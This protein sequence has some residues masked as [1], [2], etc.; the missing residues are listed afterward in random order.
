[1]PYAFQKY[2]QS[3][4]VTLIWGDC[5]PP[6]TDDLGE[7]LDSRFYQPAYYKTHG[8]LYA[9][10]DA[11]P[12][13]RI[14]WNLAS[15]QLAAQPFSGPELLELEKL[16]Q[17]TCKE[18]ARRQLKALEIEENDLLFVLGSSDVWDR[19]AV[20]K[21][22]TIDQWHG[23]IITAERIFQAVNALGKQLKNKIKFVIPKAAMQFIKSWYDWIIPIPA[24]FALSEYRLI[25]KS[26][27][28]VINRAS[29]AVTSA[30]CAAIGAP[31]LVIPM[32]AYGYM[33]IEDFTRDLIEREL[34]FVCSH[35]DTP[36]SIQ[37]MLYHMLTRSG[38]YDQ[39]TKA[40]TEFVRVNHSKNFFNALRSF[41]QAPYQ[42]MEAQ[43]Q[44]SVGVGAH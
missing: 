10:H 25:L 5:S 41:I 22:M 7:N 14:P 39:I 19:G 32:P 38:I 23:S 37:S 31:Q 35:S 30:E 29:H 42:Q 36:E 12:K 3:G 9:W 33:N 21:W 11:L 40:R 20:G 26:A 8:L 2:V 44:G 6:D 43:T 13:S 4:D 34:T 28:I 16:W 24:N 17:I 27:N 18:E 15:Y 1:V